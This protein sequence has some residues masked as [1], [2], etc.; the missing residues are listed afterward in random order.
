MSESSGTATAAAGA[1]GAAAAVVVV[2][3]T[4]A[5]EIATAAGAASPLP[6]PPPP[7]PSGVGEVKLLPPLL[8]FPAAPGLSRPM[9][10]EVARGEVEVLVV[11]SW[12]RTRASW[13]L[14]G[15]GEEPEG[16]RC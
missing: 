6:L 3:S 8:P 14:S 9:K 1:T 13:S 7:L 15:W 11:S 16:S 12:E 5:G 10:E 2:F 4:A